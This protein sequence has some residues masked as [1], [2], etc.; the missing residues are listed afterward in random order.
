MYSV[1]ANSPP[2]SLI[3]Q[4]ESNVKALRYAKRLVSFDST[5]HLSNA[6]VSKYLEMKLT[7]HGFVVEKTEYRDKNNALKVN[8]VA[9]KGAGVGGLAYFSHSD[10]VPA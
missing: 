3:Y 5:S 4:Y 7:K 9:K 10:V 1:I 6:L 8:L 2:A